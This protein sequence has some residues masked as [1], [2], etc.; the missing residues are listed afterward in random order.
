ME[1]LDNI[2][3]ERIRSTAALHR[4]TLESLFDEL[5]IANSTL[6]KLNESQSGLTYSQLSKIA[7]YLNRGVLFFMEPGDVDE[8]EVKT[9]RF[10]SLENQKPLLSRKL[11]IIIENVER[12]RD[13]YLTLREY[14][15]EEPMPFIPRQMPSDPESAADI[16]R[17]WLGISLDNSFAATRVALEAAGALVIRSNGYHGRWQV[18]KDE[19]V[20]GFSLYF[21]VCPVIFVRKQEAESRQL[22]T[23][24]HE[25]GHLLLHR[26]HFI[27]GRKEFYAK[28]KHEAEANRFAGLFL[29]PDEALRQIVDKDKPSSVLAFADWL[30]PQTKLLGVSTETILRRLR[31]AERITNREY[32]DYRQWRSEQIQAQSE[33][34][35]RI[36]R[37]REPRHIFGD[38]FVSAVIQ[39]FR[40]SRISL[41]QASQ[42]LDNLKAEDVRKLEAYYESR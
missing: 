5:K 7:N 9:A 2:N 26:T 42:Y 34:G 32:N 22:F 19:D 35:S 24:A 14:I 1:R 36:Y 11:R 29:V 30:R 15:N 10:R 21:D 31:D 6:D 13:V 37:H 38:H 20:L 16:A 27:D 40:E 12:Y 33:G 39:A 4:L 18:P 28:S 17:D 23:L 3:V 8:S 25:L 41:V